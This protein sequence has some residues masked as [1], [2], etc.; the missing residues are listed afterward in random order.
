MST[1]AALQKCRPTRPTEPR[2]ERG[3]MFVDEG[4]RRAVAGVSLT[5]SVFRLP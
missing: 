2:H 4:R 3:F 1:D 5:I